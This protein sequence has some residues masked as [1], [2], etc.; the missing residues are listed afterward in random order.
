MKQDKSYEQPNLDEVVNKVDTH[1]FRIGQSRPDASG[2]V[3]ALK[4]APFIKIGETYESFIYRYEI[5]FKAERK[6]ALQRFGK[7]GGL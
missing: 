3:E 6:E 7:E 1:T 5:W 4:T 2:L